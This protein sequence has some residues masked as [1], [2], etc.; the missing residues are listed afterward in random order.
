M[1]MKKLYF[2]MLCFLLFTSALDAKTIYVTPTASNATGGGL[3]WSDPVG[4]TRAATLANTSGDIVYVMGG[5]YNLSKSAATAAGAF[6]TSGGVSYYGSFAGT[7]SS[8]SERATSDADGNGIVETWEFTNQTIINFTLTNSAAAFTSSNASSAVTSINGFKFT[9]TNTESTFSPT[10]SATATMRIGKN[11]LFENNIIGNWTVTGTLDGTNNQ[12]PFFYIFYETGNNGNTVINN[13]LFENNNLSYTATSSLAADNPFYP[14][15]CLS[16][17]NALNGNILSNCIIRN[18]KITMD[19]SLST[20]TS[21]NNQRGLIVG[22]RTPLVGFPTTLQNTVIHNNDVTFIP[23][24]GVFSCYGAVVYTY[25]QTTAASDY[26][27]NCTVANNKTTRCSSAGIKIGMDI[28]APNEKP[29]HTVMNNVMF[30][31]FNN[32]T[33]NNFMA[34]VPIPITSTTTVASNICNGGAKNIA[35]V[36]FLQVN[37]LFDLSNDNSNATNG[38]HF[39]RPTTVI[40]NV[41]DGSS[42]NSIWTIR[43]NSY[44]KWKGMVTNATK[45]KAGYNY[46]D[47]PSVGAYEYNPNQFTAVHNPQGQGAFEIY[48]NPAQNS[49]KIKTTDG[50]NVSIYT[51]TGA[52]VSSVSNMTDG[53]QT[54]NIADLPKGSY[55]VTLSSEGMILNQKLIKK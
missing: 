33:I 48:P 27:I 47:T 17:A 42:E 9:G 41:N 25:N 34:N 21:A 12:T 39:T 7:E 19:Y 20:A 54:V 10:S 31:N 44:L 24:A 23:Q 30:N 1:F 8:P 46:S 16:N 32:D 26:I 52:L 50:A 40:G 45:D 4:L 28:N 36:S 3:S 53:I 43:S 37:N 18:N 49:F 2:A 15:I 51:L 22:I 5:T 14:F 13:C 55:L 38:A 35:N 6:S 29:N 11:I